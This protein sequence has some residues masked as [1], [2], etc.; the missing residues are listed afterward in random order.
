SGGTTAYTYSKDGLTFQSSNVFS[1]LSAGNYTLTVK[2]E[3]GC[4]AT[5]STTLT[6]PNLL[7]LTATPTNLTCQANSTGSISLLASGGTTAYTFSK[8]GSTFQSSNVFSSLSAGNYILTVKD[9][10]GCTATASTTLTEPNLLTLTAT[11]TNLTCQANSTGSISL[12]ASGGTMAYTYSK[13]GLTFQSSNV[14]SALSAGNYT[15]TVKDAN[16]CTATASTT[17]TEPELLTL[18]ATPTNL[19]C[20]SNSTGSISLSA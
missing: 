9:A 5:A 6:E 3:N 1:A 18:T 7:T 12:S 11:P 14:F 10:N 19:T 17:L 13:D 8:D 4:T 16:G 15:L 20:Q 2:D